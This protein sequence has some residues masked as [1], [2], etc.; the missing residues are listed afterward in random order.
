MHPCRVT[1]HGY[2]YVFMMTKEQGASKYYA[3]TSGELV[4]GA[5]IMHYGEQGHTALMHYVALKGLAHFTPG[6]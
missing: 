4:S 1:Q 2:I 6:R 3:A 5:V